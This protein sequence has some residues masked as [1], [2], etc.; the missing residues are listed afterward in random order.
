[1]PELKYMSHSSKACT[2]M[3]TNQNIKYGM[4]GSVGSRDDTVKHYKNSENKWKK[5]MK[6]LKK[7]NKILHSISKKS[8][9]C[10]KT[11]NAKKIRKKD[12]KKGHHSSSNSPSDNSDSD[13]DSS[14]A[15]DSI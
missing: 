6:D 1:M 8:G 9:L 15:I 11:N 7:K 14:L 2:G 4:M 10:H 5:D 12:S 3:P 13:S